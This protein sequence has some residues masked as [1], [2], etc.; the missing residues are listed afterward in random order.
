MN[1]G[2]CTVS[3]IYTPEKGGPAYFAEAFSTWQVKNGIVPKVIT[4]TDETSL[5]DDLS[6][7]LVERITRKQRIV[8][9][10]I[11]TAFAISR[12]YKN[13]YLL[14]I[15]GCFLEAL[16][17]SLLLRTKYVAKVP[18]DI[19]WERARNDGLTD[20]SIQD[21]QELRLKL[22]YKIF[23]KLFVLSLKRARLVI[24]PSLELQNLCKLWGVEPGNILLF[25]NSVSFEDF[26]PIPGHKKNF[27]VL[28]VGRLVKWKGNREL[29]EVCHRLGL[30]LA[31][32]GNGSELESLKE[33]NQ[34]I[35]ANTIFLG[36]V[37]RNKL[38][39][40]YN[41]TRFFV[42]NSTY[43]GTSHVLLEA[44]A[45]GTFSIARS[46]VGSNDQVI[47]NYSDGLLVNNIGFSLEGAL[48]YALEDSSFVESAQ[49]LA[50]KNTRRQF[51]SNKNFENIYDVVGENRS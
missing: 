50:I 21:F 45:C 47:E 42:L 11:H 46:G 25:H 39:E 32:A 23:R 3:G 34:N 9:R 2:I 24:V 35:G 49:A 26:Y 37:P 6:G 31:I 8:V 28:S 7:F 43:E 17:S 15:N 36:E 38:C 14:L 10:Y 30:V 22:N 44:R 18:G 40:L 33:L 1:K 5:T 13:K 27:D 19:V 16:I 48:K 4:L 41:S 51:G 12:A 20:L 29:I